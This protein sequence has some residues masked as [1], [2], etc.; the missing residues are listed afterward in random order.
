MKRNVRFRLLPDDTALFRAIGSKGVYFMNKPRT[1]LWGVEE[2]DGSIVHIHARGTKYQELWV[3]PKEA[4]A[5]V[6]ERRETR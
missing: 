3:L 1:W 4:I 2:Q 6:R 5:E